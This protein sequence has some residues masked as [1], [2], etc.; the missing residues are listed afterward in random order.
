MYSTQP[1][2]A[3]LRTES[4]GA[5]KTCKHSMSRYKR[6]ALRVAIGIKHGRLDANLRAPKV[7]CCH[8]I[9]VEVRALRGS[10]APR[11]RRA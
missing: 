9:Q 8:S 5:S 11:E 10:V 2:K 1:I 6:A 4:R 3:A 7:L